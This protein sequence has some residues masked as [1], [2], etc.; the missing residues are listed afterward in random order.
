MNFR[1]DLALERK[2]YVKKETLDGIISSEKTIGEITVNT[3]EVINENGQKLLQ[4]PKGKYITV[5][6]GSFVKNPDYSNEVIE[7]LANEI[8]ALLPSEGSVLVAGLGNESITPDA[9]GPKCVSLLLATRHIGSELAKAIG[10]DSLRSAAAIAPGV[11]G[12]TGIETAEIIEAVVKKIKPGAV[13]AVDALASRKL[14]RLG[15][16]VQ[17]TDSGI[18]PGSGVGNRRS[19]LCAESLGVPVVAIGVP[20]VVDGETMVFDILQ[21]N[22]IEPKELLEKNE[23]S[24][25]VT[26]KEVDLMIER[27]AAL[28]AMSINRA[29]QPEISCEDILK[30]VV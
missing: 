14:S 21:E 19:S 24:M 23:G 6:I 22:G 9:L 11:L 10:F 18:S 12:K 3:I 13:V 28:V 20:T 15:T 8:S 16:T 7:V 2:E 30:L 1:T 27:A 17:L 5:Q 4:K 26:P 25:M 29:L